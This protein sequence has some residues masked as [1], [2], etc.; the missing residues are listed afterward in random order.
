[1]RYGTVPGIAKPISR[2]VQGTVM[3]R[4]HVEAASFQLLD[5]VFALGCNTF[6]SAHIYAQGDCERTL[7]RWIHQRGV[8]DQVVLSTKFGFDIDL[9]TGERRGGV[10]SQPEHIRQ[11][12]DAQLRRLRTDRIDLLYL[13]ARSDTTTPLEDTLATAEWL[14]ESGKV[15]AIASYGHTAA[16]LVEA[17][18]QPSTAAPHREPVGGEPQR[19]AEPRQ[20]HSHPAH[21]TDES[22]SQRSGCW[23]CGAD[24]PEHAGHQS[25]HPS[26]SGSG[27]RVY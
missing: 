9:N 17:E 27:D 12:V 6:D 26:C 5:D 8:R 3:I 1:M 7:G 19:E 18:G 24:H 2:L 21:S 15:R 14:V 23:L 22:G 11:V 10:N 25:D 20:G 4:S 16:Q 13:H